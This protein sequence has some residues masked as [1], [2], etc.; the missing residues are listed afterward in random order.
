MIELLVVITIVA[1]LAAMSFA[2]INAALTKTKTTQAKAAADNVAKAVRDF[3]TKYSYLPPV[4]DEQRVDLNSQSGVELLK[5]LLAE[6]DEGSKIYNKSKITFLKAETAKS[7]KN[8]L[9]YGPGGNSST[10][11]GMYDTFGNTYTVFMNID[12]E[13][14]L[15]F[16]WGNKQY[17]L[18]NED[19]AVCSPGADMTVGTDD[20]VLTFNK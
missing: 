14:K 13:K 6:E 11:R 4:S 8:G 2:G 5:I 15:E 18:R 3:Q 7:R 12:G 1:A 19:V 20:D 10:V 17:E 16:M 9:D